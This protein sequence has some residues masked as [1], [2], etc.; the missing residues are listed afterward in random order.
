MAGL[1]LLMILTRRKAF[2]PTKTLFERTLQ[3]IW[4]AGAAGSV[5]GLGLGIVRYRGMDKHELRRKRVELQFAVRPGS[6][7]PSIVRTTR[8]IG[9]IHYRKRTS[10]EMVWRL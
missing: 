4:M 8:S 7:P 9:L 6:L 1:P 2:K 3:S 5:T 10:E